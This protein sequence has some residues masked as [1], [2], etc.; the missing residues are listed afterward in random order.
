[1]LGGQKRGVD[2]EGNTLIEDE[3]ECGVGDL[4]LGNREGE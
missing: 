2:R 1:M 4:S 3:E